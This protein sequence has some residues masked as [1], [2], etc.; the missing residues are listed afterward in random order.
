VAQKRP[1]DDPKNRSS[2]HGKSG[3]TE[4]RDTALSAA[5]MGRVYLNSDSY[6][7]ALAYFVRAEENALRSDMTD[8]ELASLYVDIAACHLGLGRHDKARSYIAQVEELE[9]GSEHDEIRAEA[10]VVLAR[11]EVKAGRFRKS[12]VAADRAYAL[13]RKKPDSP[14]L[15][16][17]SRVL[18]TAHAELGNSTGARDC[19]V[20]CLVCNR[21]LGND[22]GMAGAYN[23]LGILAKRSGDL[24]SAIDYFERAL[25]I[26]RR[27][28]STP[29]QQP[30]RGALQDV[31]VVGGGDESEKG[32]G[33]LR[34]TRSRAR[35]GFGRVRSG[36]RLSCAPRLGGSEKALHKRAEREP[37]GGLSEGGGAGTG[38]PG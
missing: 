21:R 14:L 3:S 18:G 35:R 32:A 31:E 20:D 8:A 4:A 19:F 6:S 1:D 34:G 5:R 11:T 36:Q 29:P 33:D 16:E 17:A 9:L 30:R 23:N 25:E 10:G 12:L 27:L 26:D 2:A 37:G 28:D 15:A 38:V 24:A 22:E 13:L 7:D